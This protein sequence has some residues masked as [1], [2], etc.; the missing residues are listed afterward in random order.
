MQKLK[1]KILRGLLTVTLVLSL[2]VLPS[3]SQTQF[4]KPVGHVNDF[5]NII[6]NDIEQK[7]EAL[8]LEVRQKTGAQIAVVTVKT[9]G[10]EDYNEYANKLFRAWG[11]GEKGK[12]NGVLLFN[13]VKERKFRME[14]GYGLESIIPDG[15]AGEIRDKYVFPYFRKDDYGNGYRAGTRA[16]ANIIAKDAGVQI[17]AAR[18][19]LPSPIRKRQTQRRNSDLWNTDTIFL[20]VVGIG[21]VIVLLSFLYRPQQAW[22]DSEGDLA[23]SIVVGRVGIVGAE[24]TATVAA[25]AVASAA[26]LAGSAV[27]TV[28]AAA[29]EVGIS[30]FVAHYDSLD[31]G[32]Q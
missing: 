17:G 11:I 8:C 1:C 20:L 23:V 7:I 25:E 15:L 28:V 22:W 4:P 21:F 12:D 18:E 30:S 14:V 2:P 19:L 32:P 9:I 29:R 16:V 24:A 5:A 27:G 3:V 31:L 13:A 10:D 6:P 26:A